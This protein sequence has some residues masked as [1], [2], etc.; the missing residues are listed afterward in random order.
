MVLIDGRRLAE[1]MVRY[2]VGVFIS[3]TYEIKRLDSEFL[4]EL[5]GELE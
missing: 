3:R 2:N 1:L 5:E 4:A